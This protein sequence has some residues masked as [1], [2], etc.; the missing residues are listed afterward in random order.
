MGDAMTD[1]RLAEIESDL[2]PSGYSGMHECDLP[3]FDAACELLYEVKRLREK[4]Q[5]RQRTKT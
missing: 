1:E 2:A 5:R 4:W 3:V